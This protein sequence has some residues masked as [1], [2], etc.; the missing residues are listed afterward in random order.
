MMLSCVCAWKHG[1]AARG[2]RRHDDRYGPPTRMFGIDEA[3]VLARDGF[4]GRAGRQVNRHHAR[5]DDRALLRV[6]STM[7][8]IVPVVIC[9]VRR[10]R[11]RT[12]ER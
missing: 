6:L 12:E 11:R 10:T 4:I 1:A 7:P 3:A 5:A 9:A 2:V 8:V